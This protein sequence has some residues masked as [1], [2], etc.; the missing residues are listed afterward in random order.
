MISD[1]EK[2]YRSLISFII[3]YLKNDHIPHFFIRSVNLMEKNPLTNRESSMCVAFFINLEQQEISNIFCL[4]GKI[5]MAINNVRENNC[6]LH[7]LIS[8]LLL[9]LLLLAAMTAI[10]P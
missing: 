3:M 1:F 8:M 7:F 5:E 10:H 9:M 2:N 4:T 6:F